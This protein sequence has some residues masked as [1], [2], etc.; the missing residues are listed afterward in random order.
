MLIIEMGKLESTGANIKILLVIEINQDKIN[1]RPYW[2]YDNYR[3]GQIR[4]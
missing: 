4:N 3:D 1:R 2:I